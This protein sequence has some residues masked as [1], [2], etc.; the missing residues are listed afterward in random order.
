MASKKEKLKSKK[1]A[2]NEYRKN[3]AY[4]LRKIGSDYVETHM[5]AIHSVGVATGT[6]IQSF[7]RDVLRDRSRLKIGLKAQSTAFKSYMGDTF[8]NMKADLKS[9][10]LYNDERFDSGDTTL[11]GLMNSYLDD[12][13]GGAEDPAAYAEYRTAGGN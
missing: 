2:G 8:A 5:P 12:D 6:V 13:S 3:M 7:R 9:G 10:R 1:K 4:S 11:G